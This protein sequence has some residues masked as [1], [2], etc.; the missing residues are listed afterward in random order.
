MPAVPAAAAVGAGAAAV[1]GVDG[2]AGPRRS[3][4]PGAFGV[5]ASG[6]VTVEAA[7]VLRGTIGDRWQCELEL[8]VRD[9]V[10]SRRGV[11]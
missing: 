9:Q 6:A 3:R 7:R 2:L 8:C 10:L 1:T 4:L 5:V 11:C